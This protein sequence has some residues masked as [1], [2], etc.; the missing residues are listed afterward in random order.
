MPFSYF[1]NEG[2]KILDLHVNWEWKLI[3][4]TEKYKMYEYHNKLFNQL[5][6]T[7]DCFNNIF[8]SNANYLNNYSG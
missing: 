6:I 5:K 4:F 2:A 1:L 8:L 3:Y 7:V